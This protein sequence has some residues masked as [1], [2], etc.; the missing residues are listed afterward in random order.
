MRRAACD[1][2]LSRSRHARSF[3]S[4]S[5]AGTSAPPDHHP[6]L[7]GYRRHRI[8][9]V[10]GGDVRGRRRPRLMAIACRASAAMPAEVGQ[11]ASCSTGLVA[12]VIRCG[13]ASP[14]VE[15]VAGVVVDHVL[16]GK[17]AEPRQ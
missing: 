8:V 1:G 15:A 5:A 14:A 3:S 13:Q 9:A 11:R 10:A 7:L 6:Y 17:V 16:A 12:R 2:R 4:R